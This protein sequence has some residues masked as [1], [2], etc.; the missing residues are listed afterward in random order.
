M[1]QGDK[2]ARLENLVAC[3]LLKAIHQAQ[4][5]EGVDFEL[6]YIRDKDGR[7][8]DFFIS[9]QDKPFKLIEVKWKDDR[10]SPNFKRF[11]AKEPLSRI[12][13]IGDLA[14]NKSYPGGERIVSAL[15]FLGLHFI[16]PL[17]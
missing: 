2:G 17:K 3:A 10:L 7:E 12:Q 15:D 8:I 1:V 6:N 9:Q 11:L 4:D 16:H 14:Q 13:V 5:V